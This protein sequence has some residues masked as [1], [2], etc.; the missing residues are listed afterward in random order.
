[1]KRFAPVL[2]V[3]GFVITLAGCT[4]ATVSETPTST[5]TSETS[6]TTNS[7]QATS[8]ELTLVSLKVP[9]MV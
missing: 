8:S 6:S 7:S 9:N 5:E 4:P 3:A 1:M 2:L